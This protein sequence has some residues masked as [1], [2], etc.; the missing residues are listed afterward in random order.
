MNLVFPHEPL[1]AFDRSRS[2]ARRPDILEF[3]GKSF[4]F[5][6]VVVMPGDASSVLAPSSDAR[7][8]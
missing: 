8:P 6:L 3:D 5:L 2:A 7:S 4:L 1:A